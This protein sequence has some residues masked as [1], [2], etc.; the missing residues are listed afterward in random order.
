MAVLLEDE[1]RNRDL[2]ALE[3]LLRV[4]I[5]EIG[6]AGWY[7]VDPAVDAMLRNRFRALW[8]KGARGSLARY[9][10]SPRKALAVIILLDQ[11]PRNMFR[12]SPMAFS[13]DSL[14]RKYA[15]IAIHRGYDMR[16]PEPERQ[17][18]YLPLM[19]SEC[20][21]DQERSVRLFK[22]RMPATGKENLPHARAHREII[23]RYGRFPTRNA[24]LKRQD[25]P[26]E[27]EFLEKGG[28]GSVLRE[29]SA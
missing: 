1:S 16:I 6:P 3:E 18:F 8:E 12:G 22:E 15:K 7:K 9:I 5:D 26:A 28:Y 2:A 13:T 11:L 24:A 25:T 14:A 21:S 29:L 27:S 20:I 4:W 17:F 19:H 23:R 10:T